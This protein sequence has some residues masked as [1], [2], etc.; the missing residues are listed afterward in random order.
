MLILF[1]VLAASVVFGS[2]C[3][4]F[5]PEKDNN[6]RGI[7]ELAA[8][9]LQNTKTKYLCD[10]EP[11]PAHAESGFSVMDGKHQVAFYKYN[12]KSKKQTK[13]L[14]YIKKN[15]CLFLVG[16][17]YPAM[18]NG[19]FVMIDFEETPQRQQLIDAFMSF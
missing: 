13:K 10:M 1:A 6:D 7:R 11:G 15:K 17:K 5:L 2:S 19:S 16:Y 12:K 18:V 8:H 9:M 3:S 14:D 4:L